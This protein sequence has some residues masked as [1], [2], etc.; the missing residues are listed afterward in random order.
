VIPGAFGSLLRE[1]GSGRE[2]WPGPGARLLLGRYRELAVTFDEDTLEPLAGVVE[3]PSVLPERLGQD[4]YGELLRTLERYG[5]YRRRSLGEPPAAK[6]SYYVFAEDWRFD[7]TLAAQGLHDLI[8]G[9]RRDHRDA[10]LRVDLLAHSNGGLLARYYARFGPAALR[11]D[12]T[13][14]EGAPHA[15][16]IRR[17]LLIGTPNLGT[18]QPVVVF[19]RGDGALSA[20]AAPRWGDLLRRLLVRTRIE[21]PALEMG[22]TRRALHRGGRASP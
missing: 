17:M 16:T 2:I 8:E 14:T 21:P 10:S 13:P 3:A 7:N 19:V 12:E 5:G 18:L 4:F 9:I 22:G 20:P 11:G 1:A 6:R 15:A